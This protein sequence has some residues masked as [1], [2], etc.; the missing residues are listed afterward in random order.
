MDGVAPTGAIFAGVAAAVPQKG[1]KQSPNFLKAEDMAKRNLNPERIRQETGFFKDE[2]G[3]WRFEIS[4]K[5]ARLK[6]TPVIGGREW[7]LSEVL[8]HPTLFKLYPDLRDLPVRADM[9]EGFKAH[10]EPMEGPEKPF[11][12]IVL[13]HELKSSE[14]KLTTLLH[15]IQHAVQDR[16]GLFDQKYYVP[17][18]ASTLELEMHKRFKV[19]DR[20]L[21]E[22]I[23]LS[24]LESE[25]WKQLNEIL[26]KID[27]LR[28]EGKGA[29]IDIILQEEAPY[30]DQ[31]HEREAYNVQERQHLTTQ[32][33]LKTPIKKSTKL[34]WSKVLRNLLRAL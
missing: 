15:E 31:L 32:E 11:G 24:K 25:Q 20:K 4:D 30:Q 23:P 13:G 1:G 19:L 21:E 27:K 3:N 9:L 2:L 5:D 22:R 28:D 14:G 7:K 12:R 6:R 16:E 18:T 33:R 34:Q 26:E 10:Y 17:R 29:T 8:D